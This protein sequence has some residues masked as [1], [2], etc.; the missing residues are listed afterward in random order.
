MTREETV[1]L[2]RFIKAVSPA[3]A[4]DEWTPNFWHDIIGRLEFEEA[5]NAVIAVKH[6]QPFVDPSDIIRE[7]ER[8]KTR[9]IGG[10]PARHPSARPVREAIAAS[11]M[12]D[13]AAG[14]LTPPNKEYRQAKKELLERLKARDSD[15]LGDA[16]RHPPVT[17]GDRHK[18][19][20]VK[21]EWCGAQPGSRCVNTVESTPKTEPHPS[22]VAQGRAAAA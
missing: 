11:T 10:D 22:R 5:R 2:V 6:S 18:A 7:V 12:R 4:I 1:A 9:V 19:Y 15:A 16:P 8:V 17:P 20:A 3:Q 21:C 13:D 14:P